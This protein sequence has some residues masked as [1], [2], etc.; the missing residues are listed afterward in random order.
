M[1]AHP[2]RLP[3]RRGRRGRVDGRRRL[4]GLDIPFVHATGSAF[5]EFGPAEVSD[6][7]TPTL[8]RAER[9][10]AHPGPW[11][12]SQPGPATSSPIAAYR[13]E[14]TDAA[15]VAQLELEAEGHPGVVEPG[16]AAVRFSNPTTVG[17]V[18][19]TIRAERHR[20]RAGVCTA[21]RREVGS[22]VWQVFD[23]CGRVSVGDRRHRHRRPPGPARG[24][25]GL[26]ATAYVAHR[27]ALP[28]GDIADAGDLALN[29]VVFY[30]G[31]YRHL[32]QYPS[33][34]CGVPAVMGGVDEQ[35]GGPAA[36]TVGQARRGARRSACSRR[37]STSSWLGSATRCGGPDSASPATSAPPPGLRT[38][39]ARQL[40]S[41]RTRLAAGERQRVQARHRRTPSPWTSA[42]EVSS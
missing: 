17:D 13:W 27:G 6:R 14:H 30:V 36:D 26:P 40:R 19:P 11:P 28:I 35:R 24:R 41:A 32:V 22:A 21:V 33:V 15:L 31:P 34:V 1:P 9:L 5:F 25:R 10:W 2:A 37:R 18:I 20:L 3:V 42:T 16:H 4:D 23:G 29:D 7:S 39:T 12:V 38:G 8:S